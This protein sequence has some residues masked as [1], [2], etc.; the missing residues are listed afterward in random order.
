MANHNTWGFDKGFSTTAWLKTW[1]LQ[2]QIT[3]QLLLTTANYSTYGF[4]AANHMTGGFY[5]SLSQHKGNLQHPI[6]THKDFPTGN[7]SSCLFQQPVT[8]HGALQS[9]ITTRR[10][11]QQP[12]KPEGYFTTTQGSFTTANHSKGGFKGVVDPK[13][14]MYLLSTQPHAYWRSGLVF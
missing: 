13:M 4:T 5:K 11:F 14:K 7:Q 10:V 9:P 1:I 3:A 8:S 12:V 2:Q 6:T